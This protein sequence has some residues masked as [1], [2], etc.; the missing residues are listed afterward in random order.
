MAVALAADGYAWTSSTKNKQ[1]T[2]CG[3]LELVIA[4][5]NSRASLSLIQYFAGAEVSVLC[6][7]HINEAFYHAKTDY[8]NSAFI[9]NATVMVE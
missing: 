4:R 5:S 6:I 9:A 2:E 8:H 3:K 1:I 7:F